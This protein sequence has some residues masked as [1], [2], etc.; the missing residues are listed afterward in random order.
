[1]SIP[2]GVTRELS[3]KCRV[4]CDSSH[5]AGFTL[6]LVII[7]RTDSIEDTLL[8]TIWEE[9]L[10]SCQRKA[11]WKAHHNRAIRWGFQWAF[12]RAFHWAFRWAFQVSMNQAPSLVEQ[13][14]PHNVSH[15][16]NTNSAMN[17]VGKV[18]ENNA[19]L[20]AAKPIPQSS[21]SDS[22]CEAVPAVKSLLPVTQ[23]FPAVPHP[24]EITDKDLKTSESSSKEHV[25]NNSSVE[26]G[27]VVPAVTPAL[28]T[29]SATTAS[30]AK[31]AA[32][33]DANEIGKVSP[34][35]D[36][37]KSPLKE[38]KLKEATSAPKLATESVDE[39]EVKEEALSKVET[40]STLLLRSGYNFSL[41]S[42]VY[43]TFKKACGEGF[44]YLILTEDKA[45]Q[46]CR[47]KNA[48]C[49]SKPSRSYLH[50]FSSIDVEICTSCTFLRGEHLAVRNAE[51]GFYICE[52][53]QN[54]NRQ[55]KHIK[56]R[57]LSPK[58]NDPSIYTPDFCD[59]ADFECI[60]T[61]VP[62]KKAGKDGFRLP[63][64]EEDRIKL[65]LSRSLE[66]TEKKGNVSFERKEQLPEG[67]DISSVQTEEHLQQLMV[68]Q[69]EMNKSKKSSKK[70]SSSE[71]SSSSSPSPAKRSKKT[72]SSAQKSAKQGASP[73]EGES[74]SAG[75]GGSRN[76]P[77]RV[78]AS[79]A[80]KKSQ[81]IKEDSDQDESSSDDSEDDDSDTSE[82]APPPKKMRTAPP[83]ISLPSASSSRTPRRPPVP[84]L[85]EKKAA[86]KRTPAAAAASTSSTSPL[87]EK[88][89][90]VSKK[91]DSPPSRQAGRTTSAT[92]ASTAS[93]ASSPSGTAPVRAKRSTAK[94][95]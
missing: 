69:L 65:I 11:Q 91:T 95:T 73:K 14:Q 80:N 92:K 60:L 7:D 45:E 63:A 50:W 9:L 40:F 55:S 34:T 33:S 54:I 25:G 6:G 42:E 27:S 74:R 61:S 49:Y 85:A 8:K 82:E 20:L 66:F 76:L 4:R 32:Q 84:T 52:A 16:A 29:A 62:M 64:E 10:W 93:S 31:T 28:N 38:E 44:C 24:T 83:P 22:K 78:A 46:T 77:S 21:S 70:R 37:K 59:Q 88:T 48:S 12:R 87:A 89:T 56:I 36:V 1:M 43:D 71:A 79:V 94:K 68:S 15:S 13:H 57:W 72:A 67:I 2:F 5:H 30:P 47:G 18:Q 39:P 86:G 26:D 35:N 90:G 75:R 23:P 3:F 58:E 53:L 19:G 51:G 41:N 81:L 17:S